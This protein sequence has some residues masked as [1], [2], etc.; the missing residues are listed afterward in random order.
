MVADHLDT[1]HSKTTQAL[2]HRVAPIGPAPCKG[3]TPQLPSVNH[4]GGDCLHWCRLL[5]LSSKRHLPLLLLLPSNERRL[6]QSL[7]SR[8]RRLPL[9]LLLLSSGRH[10]PL[11]LLPCGHC[12]LSLMC[13]L[14]AAR[15]PCD[16]P[17]AQN[18][19]S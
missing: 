16:G 11:L 18:A 8:G 14:L 3:G 17:N 2:H 13:V 6:P 12:L 5:L 4:V 19:V 7:L 10:L 9:L 15:P 1:H